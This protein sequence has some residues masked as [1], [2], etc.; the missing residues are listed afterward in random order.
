MVEDGGDTG[1]GGGGGDGETVWLD[2][3][4]KGKQEREKGWSWHSSDNE[5][6]VGACFQGMTRFNFEILFLG[7]YD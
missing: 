5:E 3:A 6:K 7:I 1:G 4:V 2:M